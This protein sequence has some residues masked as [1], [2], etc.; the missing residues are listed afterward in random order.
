MRVQL[1]TPFV[2][3]VKE[4]VI[5]SSAVRCSLYSSIG[6][7]SAAH[8]PEDEVQVDTLERNYLGAVTQDAESSAWTVEIWMGTKQVTFKLE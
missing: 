8:E 2:I 6:R 4:E 7:T 3:A 5:H 1:K